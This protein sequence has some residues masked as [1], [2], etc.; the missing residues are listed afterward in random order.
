MPPI[1]TRRGARSAATIVAAAALGIALADGTHSSAAGAPPPIANIATNTL[2][3]DG[4]AEFC[5]YTG[6]T[7][8]YGQPRPTQARFI[9]VKEDLVRATLVK[10][11]VGPVAGKTLEVLKLNFVA[12]FPTGTYAYHQMATTMF[13]RATLDVLKETMSHSESCG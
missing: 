6:T 13:D 2:W 1:T 4:K 3:D 10:S 8:R 5:T 9:L 11:D 7:L 12:D